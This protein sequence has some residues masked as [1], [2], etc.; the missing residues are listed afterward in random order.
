[1]HRIKALQSSINCQVILPLS[2]SIINRLLVM[3]Q[4]SDGA[5]YDGLSAE[6]DDIVVLQHLL[7]KINSEKGNTGSIHEINAGNAGTVMRFLTA[8]LSITPG[9]W[10]LTGSGRMQQRPLKPLTDALQQIGAELSF[11]DKTGFPPVF[12][13]GNPILKGGSVKVDAG[14]SSQYISALMMVAPVLK[15]GLTIEL[16]GAVTSGAYIRM[17]QALMQ[18]AGINVEFIENTIRIQEGIY[19]KF[20]FNALSE[21]DWSAAAFWFEI[22]ALS[23]QA[24][25]F[26]KGLK[27]DSVQGD[28]VLTEIFEN[29]GV[30]SQF[31]DEGLLLTKSGEAI[32][33]NFNYDFT[34]CPDLAQAV[35]VTCAAL[36]IKGRFTGLKT[37]RIK[38]TDR[39]G[40]LQHE[41]SKLGY[42][43][44]VD[45][46]DI[47]LYGTD[48]LFHSETDP[49]MIKCYDDHRMAMSFAPLALIRSD[50]S[51]DDPLVVKKSYPGF[52]RDMESAG[53]VS[54]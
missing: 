7:K 24:E 28:K 41:L 16:Q 23:K 8:L 31:T 13:T 20:D 32:A 39:I 47:L 9:K 51:I 45:G 50:I 19:Q 35:I 37:L 10:L 1:M 46:N 52:W 43:V 33:R 22:V 38:E 49:V 36:G 6:A 29:L 3:N 53:I 34:E 27:V 30:T 2:K 11:A 12:I 21:P 48:P 54:G 4:L 26:L 17:T 18:K 5:D 42:R 40:A 44:E 25:V 15:G 14:I